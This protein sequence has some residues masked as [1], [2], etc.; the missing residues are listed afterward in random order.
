[1]LRCNFR[2]PSRRRPR[3]TSNYI[4]RATAD[5]IKMILRKGSQIRFL[6]LSVLVSWRSSWL[7]FRGS[8]AFIRNFK[9]CSGTVNIR[10]AI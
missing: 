8:L 9:L 1:M 7:A 6:F 4:M 5:T 10:I 2:P 3:V